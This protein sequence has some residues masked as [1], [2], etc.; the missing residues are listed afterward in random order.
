MTMTFDAFREIL[1]MI[2]FQ[3][4]LGFRDG[5]DNKAGEIRKCLAI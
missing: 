3:K 4:E 2:S 5:E 1:E